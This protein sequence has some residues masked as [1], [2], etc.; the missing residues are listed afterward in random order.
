M[1]CGKAGQ[2]MRE[3]KFRGCKKG[4][5]EWVHGNLMQDGI[6]VCIQELDSIFPV[7][8]ETVG[9]YIE[10]LKAYEGDVLYMSDAGRE[11]GPNAW[12]GVVEF[13]SACG[14]IRIFDLVEEAWYEIDDY[15]F[16]GVIGNIHDN[17]EF[18]R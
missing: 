5:M 1:T 3:I 7:E 9:E 16:D 4:T 12:K 8:P 18:K 6:S 11:Y 15:E 14:R 2:K 10:H 13:D 17:P